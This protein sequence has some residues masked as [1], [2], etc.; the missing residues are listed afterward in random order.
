MQDGPPLEISS[1]GLVAR[2][3]SPKGDDEQ[4]IAVNPFGYETPFGEVLGHAHELFEVGDAG[5]LHDPCP[6]DVHPGVSF[7]VRNGRLQDR[8]RQAP[9]RNTLPSHCPTSHVRQGAPLR[10][11][12]QPRGRLPGN[13]RSARVLISPMLPQVGSSRLGSYHEKIDARNQKPSYSM[14]Q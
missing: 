3:D 12:K 8:K 6:R 1:L 4:L 14:L 7:R 9:H 11:T 13:A 10:S 5:L 2:T